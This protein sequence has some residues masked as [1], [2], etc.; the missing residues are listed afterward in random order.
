MFT[1]SCLMAQTGWQ[2]ASLP[3][4]PP[5]ADSVLSFPGW[6]VLC[7][8]ESARAPHCTRV[9]EL[10]DSLLKFSVDFKSTRARFCS[11]VSLRRWTGL[12]DIKQEKSGEKKQK[13]KG[14]ETGDAELHHSLSFN[15]SRTRRVPILKADQ[16][17]HLA[18]KQKNFLAAWPG[19]SS[20]HVEGLD[21]R[22]RSV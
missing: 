22:S 20:E 19:R 7:V 10:H 11:C 5:L 1:D 3:R 15:S 17:K 6:R 18:F 21:K 12:L 9:L 2:L 13:G 14:E 4:K 8:V 16:G